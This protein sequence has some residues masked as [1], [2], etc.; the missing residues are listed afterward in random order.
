MACT[1]GCG[2]AWLGT[3]STALLLLAVIVAVNN[4]DLDLDESDVFCLP[5]HNSATTS[6]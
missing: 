3:L 2:L 5:G 1:L 6:V 4:L